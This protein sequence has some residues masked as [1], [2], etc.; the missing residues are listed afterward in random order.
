[1]EEHK[2]AVKRV[3]TKYNHEF[4]VSSK[5]LISCFQSC[6]LRFKMRQ[7][8]VVRKTLRLG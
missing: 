5:I 1:M 7:N 3:T 8:Y 4:T 6:C 2:A